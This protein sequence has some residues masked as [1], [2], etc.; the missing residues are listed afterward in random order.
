MGGLH[1]SK[2]QKSTLKPSIIIV[3]CQVMDLIY[4]EQSSDP[5]IDTRAWDEASPIG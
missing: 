5:A 1:I 3:C 4:H 2:V